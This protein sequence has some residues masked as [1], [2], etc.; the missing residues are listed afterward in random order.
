MKRHR[1]DEDPVRS[2][3]RDSLTEAL[4]LEP[5]D[6]REIAE[7][8]EQ[9]LHSMYDFNMYKVKYRSLLFNLKDP[10][11]K[12]LRQSVIDKH[13][14]VDELCKMSSAQLAN[15]EIAQMRKQ[16]EEKLDDQVMIK[17][18]PTMIQKVK[19]ARNVEI[20]ESRRL[21]RTF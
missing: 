10:K 8:I 14:T 13:L 17:D 19:E 4:S 7:E 6:H 18:V 16:R 2:K 1:T 9:K 21:S 3:M 11:N 15:P 5:G 12:P 20:S